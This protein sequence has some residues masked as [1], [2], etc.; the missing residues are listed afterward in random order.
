MRYYLF[1]HLIE[2]D[3]ITSP[4][5]D[6]YLIIIEITLQLIFCFILK[7]SLTNIF[8]LCLFFANRWQQSSWL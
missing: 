1:K 7:L 8:L 6:I 2:M 3:F 4:K 5:N